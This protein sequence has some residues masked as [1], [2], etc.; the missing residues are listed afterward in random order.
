M[1]NT[2]SPRHNHGRQKMN[3]TEDSNLFVVILKYIVPLDIIDKHRG[4]HLKFLEIYYQKGIFVTSGRQVPR[5][6][7]VIIAKGCER[8]EL[9]NFL[10][11]DPYFVHHLAEYEIYEFT[12]SV[13]IS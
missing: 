3:K 5:S 7:G 1:E 9:E 6:G 10:K 11:D 2:L 12:P 8:F 4:E 13:K